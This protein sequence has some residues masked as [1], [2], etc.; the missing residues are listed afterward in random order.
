MYAA[1]GSPIFTNDED[2][3]EFV[4]TLAGTTKAAMEAKSPLKA[5]LPAPG[6]TFY[7]EAWPTLGVAPKPSIVQNI[8]SGAST[9]WR[10]KGSTTTTTLPNKESPIMTNP[11]IRSEPNKIDQEQDKTLLK[12]DEDN[13]MSVPDQDHSTS[14]ISTTENITTPTTPIPTETTTTTTV[15]PTSADIPITTDLDPTLTSPRLSSSS[16]AELNSVE[17]SDVA[18]LS[19]LDEAVEDLQSEPELPEIQAET[20]QPSATEETTGHIEPI[21]SYPQ[22]DL[23]TAPASVED[24]SSNW[25]K[26]TITPDSQESVQFDNSGDT[27]SPAQT[28]SQASNKDWPDVSPANTL[29]VSSNETVP[30]DVAPVSSVG[31]PEPSCVTPVVKG[32]SGWQAFAA[33]APTNTQ[34]IPNPISSNNKQDNASK[35]QELANANIQAAQTSDHNRL[36]KSSASDQ[37]QFSGQDLEKSVG[38]WNDY[39][40]KNLSEIIPPEVVQDDTKSTEPKF[41]EDLSSSIESVT[42][43]SSPAAETSANL[44][45]KSPCDSGFASPSITIQWKDLLSGVTEKPVSGGYEQSTSWGP[46]PNL[47][48]GASQWKSFATEVQDKP[49]WGATQHQPS[50]SPKESGVPEHQHPDHDS[51]LPEKKV[52]SSGG[53]QETGSVVDGA[54]R[55]QAFASVNPRPSTWKDG[56]PDLHAHHKAGG[57][58][59]HAHDKAQHLNSSYPENHGNERNR[60]R[61]ET[62]SHSWQSDQVSSQWDKHADDNERTHMWESESGPWVNATQVNPPT[63]ETHNAAQSWSS[64]DIHGAHTD[65]I[66]SATNQYEKKHGTGNLP[67]HET[68]RSSKASLLSSASSSLESSLESNF[69]KQSVD[70]GANRWKMYATSHTTQTPTVVENLHHHHHHQHIHNHQQ[71]HHQ[72]HHPSHDNHLHSEPTGVEINQSWTQAHEKNSLEVKAVIDPPFSISPK[73]PTVGWSNMN[74]SSETSLDYHGSSFGGQTHLDKRLLTDPRLEMAAPAWQQQVR[75]RRSPRPINRDESRPMRSY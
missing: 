75:P 19:I 18:E 64:E 44:Q 42:I 14:G 48:N 72:N 27:D 36:K 37:D 62:E 61:H 1:A 13:N 10:K 58:L 28:W 68:F 60:A 52:L 20:E 59:M 24:A 6:T 46:N 17:H 67:G 55:W 21:T 16:D 23:S 41:D 15:T 22:D 11:R 39:C 26:C 29:P 12:S 73:E 50:L 7:E 43:S 71:D 40:K 66:S 32:V 54:S 31:V 30:N 63:P 34:P 4:Q 51:N 35:W 74:S 45:E 5:E 47:D 70:I 25:D 8:G 9:K 69:T 56:V 33:V 3:K 57:S 49:S 53:V 38:K 2:K 65:T